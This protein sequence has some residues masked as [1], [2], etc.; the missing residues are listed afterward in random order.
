[1]SVYTGSV[2]VPSAPGAELG[3]FELAQSDSSLQLPGAVTGT[4]L[5][6][7][8]KPFRSARVAAVWPCRMVF[9]WM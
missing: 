6:V 9:P 2:E 4:P 1:M 7:G 3:K 5:V 8:S